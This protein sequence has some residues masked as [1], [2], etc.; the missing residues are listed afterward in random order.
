MGPTGESLSWFN[1][2]LPGGLR[3]HV[4]L[5]DYLIDI[6]AV[7][8]R[9]NV[10]EDESQARVNRV[11]V[12]WNK[13][14]EAHFATDKGVLDESRT[15]GERAKRTKQTA[16]FLRQVQVLTSRTLITTIRN[17]YGVLASWLG[18]IFMGLV[19][20]LIFYQIPYNLGGI[21][22][23]QS[24]FYMINVGHS[25]LYLL[26]EIYRLSQYDI[27]LFDRERGEN[28]VTGVAWVIS[29]PIAHG[30]LE[31]FMVPFLFCFIS[32]YLAGFQGKIGIFLAVVVL[33]HYIMASFALFCVA[34]LSYTSHHP[35]CEE[36]KTLRRQ[37]Q[38]HHHPP[39]TCLDH[40]CISTQP[41]Q[42]SSR[43]RF[44]THH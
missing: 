41:R 32:S 1:G 27:P 3:P 12:A 42:I 44:N 28:L 16:P 34:L 21:R 23:A 25:Y 38:F 15:L 20:G 29:R 14:S 8:T 5:A 10:A 33:V 37:L 24:A 2:L 35:L 30:I 43:K 36:I 17:P 31:D 9:T 18:T 40:D 39:E 13:E 4:N 11:L 22:S 26:F 6:V 19:C 7:D